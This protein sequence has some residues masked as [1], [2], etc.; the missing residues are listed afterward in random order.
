MFT[1]FISCVLFE[2]NCS[3]V[4]TTYTPFYVI[5]HLQ[6]FMPCWPCISI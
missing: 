2:L 5:H 3:F 4:T 1:L 6:Y